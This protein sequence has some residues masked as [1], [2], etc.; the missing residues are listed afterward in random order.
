LLEVGPSSLK[1]GIDG[2]EEGLFRDDGVLGAE[3][4]GGGDDARDE[5]KGLR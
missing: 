5:K 1:V 3:G 4:G 2:L